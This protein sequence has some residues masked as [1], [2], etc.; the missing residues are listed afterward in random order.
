MNRQQRHQ[1]FKTT[2]KK[3]DT[4]SSVIVNRPNQLIQ[5]D[6]LYFWWSSNNVT[7]QRGDGPID[8]ETGAGVVCSLLSL[9]AFVTLWHLKWIQLAQRTFIY[10]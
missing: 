5:V 4:I 1:V 2:K 9:Y 6:Y 3:T 7:D 10:I 8:T